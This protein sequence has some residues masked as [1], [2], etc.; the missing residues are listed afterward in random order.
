MPLKIWYI[1]QCLTCNPDDPVFYTDK[2]ERDEEAQQ[3]ANVTG[4]RIE[5]GFTIR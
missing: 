3:H 2:Q 4:H 1:S 5:V